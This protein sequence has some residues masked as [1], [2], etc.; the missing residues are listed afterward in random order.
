MKKQFIVQVSRFDPAV[1]QAAYMQAFKIPAGE[2]MSLMNALDYIYENLDSSLAYYDHAAC[3]QGICKTCLAK[4]NGKPALLCQT[5]LED[6][7]T[8]EPLDKFVVVKDL[9]TTRRVK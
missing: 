2:G 3:A 7:V 4:I 5:P 6:D 1:D 9:V 8:V